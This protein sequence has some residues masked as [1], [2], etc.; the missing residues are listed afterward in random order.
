V[1]WKPISSYGFIGN[2][3]SCALVNLDGAID[4]CCLPN[5]DSPS[6]FA[7][8]LDP[9]MGGTF[10]IAPVDDP[11]TSQQEYLKDTNILKTVFK[12]P[13]GTLELTDWMHMGAFSHEET[14]E[15]L[16]PII[17]RHVRCTEGSVAVK[18]LFQPRLD[19]ARGRTELTNTSKGVVGTLSSENICLHAQAE[20][21]LAQ[22]TATTSMSL[23][24]GDEWSCHCHYGECGKIQLP[25][26]R[27]SLESTQQYWQR[28]VQ[29]CEHGEC[30]YI[31]Q[32]HETTIR[33][34]LVLKILAGGDGIAAAATTSLPEII[35]GSDNWDYRFNWIRD[36]SFT[37]QSFTQ[38]GHLHDA[39]EFLDSISSLLC[40]KGCRPADIRV[41]YP[42]H[43]LHVLEEELSHLRGYRD[44][45]P[46]RIGNGAEHQKQWDIYGE[47]LET[48]YRSEHLHPDFGDQLS[49][50]L[51]D[52]VDYVCDIWREP[53]HGIWELRSEPQHYVYSKVM[54]WVALDRGIKLA[55][56]HSWNV[57]MDAWLKERD[58][59]R[60]MILEKGYNKEK[61]CFVQ[62][63]DSTSIDA[64]ALLFPIV[65]FI[66]PHHEY[67][68]NT[69]Q[70][71]QTELCNDD[72]LVFRSDYHFT[73]KQEGAFL[74]CSFWLVD[75]LSL[76]GK[77][78]EAEKLFT[79][80]LGLANHVGL[81]SEEI[82]PVTGDFL[83]NFPQ[84]F[85][86]VG[87]INSAVYLGSAKQ[88]KHPKR[89]I[90]GEKYI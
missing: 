90:M 52:I 49:R 38:M 34:L 64:T 59:L 28:W 66:D 70:T 88:K 47:I 27:Q 20:W 67:A 63:F 87:L 51:A 12:T 32:W 57:N 37:I 46:V 5:L 7:A 8:I 6:I 9:K 85:T 62:T 74:F 33:S 44:S 89:R 72:G 86:H 54:C 30:P 21:K 13:S 80:L 24:K 71:I 18:V 22:Q 3:R 45:R 11:W 16:L 50:V 1:D 75:A 14:E 69:L 77:I 35:G 17:I 73:E 41:L 55:K 40:D 58:S 19:Y 26:V 4:W 39:G 25:P 68:E 65:E 84:A 78:H 76:A 79:R 60:E 23:S 81:Y 43:N 83:G 36:T 82:D 56:E 15:H 42:L 61:R 29:E 53:D 2:L 48:V 10:R 31:G